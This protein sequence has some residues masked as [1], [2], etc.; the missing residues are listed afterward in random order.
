MYVFKENGRLTYL[1]DFELHGYAKN[2]RIGRRF[3]FP[4]NQIKIGYLENNGLLRNKTPVDIINFS[5]S[6][7]LIFCNN[8]LK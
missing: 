5:M 1:N 8:R 6:G 4:K 7:A 2:R 3:L